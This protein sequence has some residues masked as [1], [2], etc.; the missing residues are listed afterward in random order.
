MGAPKG[1]RGGGGKEKGG[2]A[3]PTAAPGAEP[4]ARWG[5][6]GMRSHA[7]NAMAEDRAPA[8]VEHLA[9]AFRRTGRT[10]INRQELHDLVL[11]ILRFH[12]SWGSR[13][14][15]ILPAARV[16]SFRS[17][18]LDM[19]LPIN[20]SIV[21]PPLDN[22]WILA[23]P[24]GKGRKGKGPLV[25]NCR[26]IEGALY[27]EEWDT[28]CCAWAD[29]TTGT[30]AKGVA[31]ATLEDVERDT[32]SIACALA[33]KD[34]ADAK[35]AIVLP[36]HIYPSRM[37]TSL[38]ARLRGKK[39]KQ[40]QGSYWDTT[41]LRYDGKKMTIIFL[42]G[43]VQFSVTENSEAFLTLRASVKLVATAVRSVT[44]DDAF[45]MIRSH[46]ADNMASKVS[47]MT[48]V[49]ILR[50]E[51]SR[52]DSECIE[53]K[54]TVSTEDADFLLTRQRQLNEVGFF[55]RTYVD[56][57]Q[58]VDDGYMAV[59]GRSE[60]SYQEV[61]ALAD[62]VR[63]NCALV[64]RRDGLGV[65]FGARVPN[66]DLARARLIFSDKGR[67]RDI[68]EV[69]DVRGTFSYICSTTEGANIRE[70]Q[71]LLFDE[72]NWKC[73]IADRQPARDSQ[74]RLLADEDPPNWIFGF[75]NVRLYLNHE[76]RRFD[77]HVEEPSPFLSTERDIPVD[78]VDDDWRTYDDSWN[79]GWS[80]WGTNW[81][82]RPR[83]GG[84][85]GTW[86]EHEDWHTSDRGWNG[87]DH[88]DG[89]IDDDMGRPTSPPYM[90]EEERRALH[91]LRKEDRRRRQEEELR[92]RFGEEYRM[93]KTRRAVPQ[94]NV[95]LSPT[96][97]GEDVGDGRPR[98]DKKDKKEKK[99]KHDKKDKKDKKEN[100]KQSRKGEPRGS[101]DVPP[102]E[103]DEDVYSYEEEKEEEEDSLSD[104]VD[105]EVVQPA[106]K[107]KG[108]AAASAGRPSLAKKSK[109]LLEAKPKQMPKPS[110][111]VLNEELRS[112][113]A[114]LR[115]KIV[116]VRER[117]AADKKNIEEANKK[118]E[119]K[120]ELARAKQAEKEKAKE[121]AH[122]EAME[123]LI[124]TTKA[125]IM[126]KVVKAER[127]K[128]ARL[129]QQIADM[130]QQFKKMEAATRARSPSETSDSKRKAQ[131]EETALAEE[132]GGKKLK[133]TPRG[134][135][136]VAPQKEGSVPEQSK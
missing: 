30:T 64:M 47:S 74:F 46:I 16:S 55:M 110:R 115:A 105:Y 97:S 122:E 37:S 72:M 114:R 57:G 77:S 78:E 123:K 84:G 19:G 133:E 71:R 118:A 7:D 44:G 101:K 39:L 59:W 9:F 28:P 116:E 121:K 18:V 62:Q 112:E 124:A 14:E 107:S 51:E 94:H 53:A 68:E 81:E 80:N 2:G 69:A 120:R 134:D 102:S 45:I 109:A 33:E 95:S 5:K 42:Y 135:G 79:N 50:K 54:L 70:I 43:S 67:A 23:R 60:H 117:A 40:T 11:E 113:A 89:G 132:G 99:N 38:A 36:G 1:A 73:L 127:E 13:F 86:H 58:I 4:A 29:L 35:V 90:S 128:V 8:V 48:N 126:E 3:V 21:S 61:A 130:A 88:D 22:G 106:Y 87:G 52:R 24:G 15:N 76:P 17:K 96:D 83:Y 103:D 93:S 136:D 85:E 66:E 12:P 119:E 98:R 125:E 63:D 26:W 65:A 131:K 31:L 32:H 10:T 20:L 111:E 49:T 75:A 34:I 91:E 82:D 27:Q 129:E 92:Q 25:T 56:K 6:G 108:A 41:V 100:A 104:E